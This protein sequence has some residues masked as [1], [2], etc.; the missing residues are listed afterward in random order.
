MSFSSFS[1]FNFYQQPNT[2]RQPT[3]LNTGILLSGNAASG[4][5]AD[6]NWYFPYVS[7]NI[8]VNSVLSQSRFG[9][10]IWA[11]SLGAVV[12]GIHYATV[13]TSFSG[14]FGANHDSL[15]FTDKFYGTVYPQMHE[16][17]SEY[18]MYSGRISGVKYDSFYEY[19][20]HS[21]K[22]SGFKH[23]EVF[24]SNVFSGEIK[25]SA[26]R[27]YVNSM[28]SGIINQTPHDVFAG[29]L[30]TSG[31]FWPTKTDLCQ[32]GYS[33]IGYSISSGVTVVPFTLN[34]AENI[35]YAL[36]GYQIN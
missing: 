19:N 16:T 21:G 18:S 1:L 17:V 8:L 14:S 7:T 5:V 26:D 24:C 29:Y 35:S 23:D 20:G 11:D 4:K 15:Y 25:S 31:Y 27:M 33:M 36:I 6:F 2:G 9:Y 32:L 13:S 28:V 10:R 12:P 30:G 3:A 22:F 34:D